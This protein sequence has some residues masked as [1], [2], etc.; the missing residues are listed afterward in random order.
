MRKLLKQL[1][2]LSQKK[3]NKSDYKKEIKIA[4]AIYRLAVEKKFDALAS[5]HINTKINLESVD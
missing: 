4:A 5:I 2:G 3:T 1:E